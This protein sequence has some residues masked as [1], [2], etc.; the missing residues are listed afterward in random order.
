MNRHPTPKHPNGGYDRLHEP[1]FEDAVA[2]IDKALEL[3]EHKRRHWICSLRRMAKSLGRPMELV[4]ARWSA[5]R[6]SLAHLHHAPLG[7]TAKTLA[8]HRA[9]AKRALLWL[10][11]ERNVPEHG[12]PLALA[13][14][15]LKGRLDRQVRWRL[16]PLMR[17]CS[18]ASISPCAVNEAVVDAYMGY[19]SRATAGRSDDAARRILARLWNAQV[20]RVEG[21]PAL[22][23]FEPPVKSSGR[24]PAWEDFP[25]GLR[26]EIERYLEG[27]GQVRRG[28]KGQR[29]RPCKQSTR[30][31]RRRELAAAARTAVAAGVPVESLNSLAALLDPSTVEKVL[32]TYWQRNGDMPKAFTIDLA[33][34]LV[35]IARETGCVTATELVRL[36]D[37]RAALEPHRRKGLTDKNYTLIRQVLTDGVWGRIVNLPHQLMATAR[38]QN[39][40]A[41]HRA[42]VTAQ[43][44]TAIAILSFA[45]V[46]L[47]NLAAIRLDSNL[48]KPRGPDSNY[49][50]MFPD[51][52]VKNRVRLEYPLTPELTKL[53]D[54][55]VHEFRPT[56]ARGSNELWLFPGERGKFKNAI[57]FSTQIVK[58]LYKATGIRMTVHQFRHA[59]GALILKHYPGNYGLVRLVLGH[60]SVQTTMES[61]C[62]L[63]SIQ[64]SEIFGKLVQEQMIF[65]PEL[66]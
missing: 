57:S 44:A 2:V 18:A 63:E 65:E 45:P 49:W 62:G 19:R 29:L 7:L 47:G 35:S 24:G 34:H 12:A 36:D 28:R 48:I 20:G 11:Q 17:F 43:L 55:Y 21:W 6:G 32:D 52:D 37:M 54:E 39:F 22:R 13:W 15:S 61:Y 42:A 8:N 56:L 3:P 10:H 41:P 23:L 30:T 1:S 58:K 14:A 60:R 64:A 38:A 25:R 51:Y 59:A 16:S 4:P 53:I 33:C 46:R 66:A 9:N 26:D 40:D 27:L 50:L 5:V 31:T